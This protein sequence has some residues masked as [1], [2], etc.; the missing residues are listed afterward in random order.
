[1][2][3]VWSEK[4]SLFKELPKELKYKISLSMYEGLAKEVWFFKGRDPSFIISMMPLMR[5]LRLEDSE[6]LYKEN[7]YADEIY[8]IS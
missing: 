2:G 1:M 3:T 7:S 5:P 6:I 8:F 4:H